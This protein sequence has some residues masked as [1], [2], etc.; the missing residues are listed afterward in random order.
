IGIERQD[1][2]RVD[3]LPDPRVDLGDLGIRL[4]LGARPLSLGGMVVARALALAGIGITFGLAGALAAGRALNTLAFETE[5]A[6]P[7]I[8]FAT[9]LVMLLI[10]VLAAAIPAR[11]ATTVD[12][13]TV[14][15]DD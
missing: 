1:D 2:D 11:E 14:L 9:T 3:A 15:Q 8:L 10:A 6:D 7:L 5:P 13:V 4:A 12:P